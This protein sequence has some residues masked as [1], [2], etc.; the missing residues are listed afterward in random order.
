M[1]PF[2]I[3]TCVLCGSL[4][5]LSLVL[6]W[7]PGND[8]SQAKE[9]MHKA[10]QATLPAKLYADT[11]GAMPEPNPRQ[12]NDLRG[13]RGNVFPRWERRAKGASKFECRK[14]DARETYPMVNW[15]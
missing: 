15:K 5:P 8:K 13:A 9:L 3:I 4:L 11:A 14:P 2:G 6:D 10:S 7:G 12:T 1:H